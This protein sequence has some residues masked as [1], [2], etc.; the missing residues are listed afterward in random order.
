MSHNFMNNSNVL[1]YIKNNKILCATSIVHLFYDGV[2]NMHYLLFTLWQQ[3]FGL[4]MGQVGMLKMLFTGAMSALQI[5]AG[6]F[7]RISGERKVLIGGTLLISTSLLLYA[8]ISSM[9]SLVVLIILA[10]ISASVQHPLA[11]SFISRHYSSE[12]TRVAL[13]TYNFFG[14]VGKRSTPF[15]IFFVTHINGLGYRHTL[16]CFSWYLCLL[17][18]SIPVTKG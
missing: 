3:Q 7:G 5:P 9:F 12:Q 15:F 18:P 17:C 1:S 14:D 11:S 16:Y 2:T 6:E 4:S 10:G 13:S 8:Y